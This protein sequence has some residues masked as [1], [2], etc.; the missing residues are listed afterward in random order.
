MSKPNFT[1]PDDWKSKPV[2][3]RWR[4]KGSARW[5]YGEEEPTGPSIHLFEVEEL[6]S[7]PR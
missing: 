5:Q 6:Y 4:H 7:H 3:W 1:E 2:A